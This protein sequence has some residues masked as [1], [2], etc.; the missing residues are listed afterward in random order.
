MTPMSCATAMLR[1]ATLLL[2]LLP[3]ASGCGGGGGDDEPSYA[4]RID[5]PAQRTAT[6]DSVVLVGDGFL[7]PGSTCSAGCSG[8]LPAPVFGQLGAYQLVWTN[9]AT[10][11]SGSAHLSWV[12]NCGGAAPYW[13]QAVPLAPGDNAITFTE[14]AGN[15]RQ[16]AT[17]TVTRL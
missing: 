14:T 7:P 3:A 15:L 9:A 11:D 17:V 2:V 5:G 1:R 13:I 10:A 12:C 16:E 6:A 8:L 4:L